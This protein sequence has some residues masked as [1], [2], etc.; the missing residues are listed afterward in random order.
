MKWKNDKREG[1]IDKV[2]LQPKRRFRKLISLG[3]SLT[4][5]RM[6]KSLHEIQMRTI[7]SHD[8]RH[9][10]CLLL[11]FANAYRRVFFSLKLS[12]SQGNCD[13]LEGD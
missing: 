11:D 1:Y 8:L 5:K 10:M 12:P 3:I 6:K 7:L 4:P 2:K 9:F 13:E